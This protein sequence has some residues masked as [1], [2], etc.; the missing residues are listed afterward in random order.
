MLCLSSEL[1]TVSGKF[2]LKPPVILSRD[3]SLGSVFLGVGFNLV[4]VCGCHEL[5][6]PHLLLKSYDVG[7]DLLCVQSLIRHA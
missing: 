6:V 2:S 3:I 7:T 4:L 1:V 5:I